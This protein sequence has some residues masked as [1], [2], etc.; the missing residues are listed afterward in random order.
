MNYIGYAPQSNEGVW[1]VN[2]LHRQ[3]ITGAWEP[4]GDPY[5]EHVALLI[6]PTKND[7]GFF[8]KSYKATYG[9]QAKSTSINNGAVVTN[10]KLV[11]NG[12]NQ[13][14]GLNDHEDWYFGT[15]DFY[16]RVKVSFDNLSGQKG[17]VTQWE[18]GVGGAWELITFNTGLQWG[19]TVISAGLTTGVE[20]DFEIT[21]ING[22]L[23]CRRDGVQTYAGAYT[24][25]LPD[26]IKGLHVGIYHG[27]AYPMA[28]KFSLLHIVKGRGYTSPPS[29]NSDTV[30]YIDFSTG[31][32]ADIAVNRGVTITKSGNVS[33]VGAGNGIYKNNAAINFT[34]SA[35]DYLVIPPR[36][37]FDL[38]PYTPY[39]LETLFIP[40][41]LPASAYV[42]YGRNGDGNSTWNSGTDYYCYVFSDGTLRAGIGTNGTEVNSGSNKVVLGIVN[43]VAVIHTGNNWVGVAVNGVVQ[44]TNIT[45][46]QI[47]AGPVYIGAPQNVNAFNGQILA[48]RFTIGSHRG[49][50]GNITTIPVPR[51]FPTQQ[52]RHNSDPYF[53]LTQILVQPKATDTAILDYAWKGDKGRRSFN[54]GGVL[55]TDWRRYGKTSGRYN[56]SSYTDFIWT[57]DFGTNDFL[58]R[59]SC[60]F[61]SLGEQ[62]PIG[63]IDASTGTNRAFTVGLNTSNIWTAGF[64]SGSSTYSLTGNTPA[65]VGVDYDVI[66]KRVNGT[67]SL[68]VNDVTV[69]T[70]SQPL[71]V[72]ASTA[73]LCIGRWGT[74]YYFNGWIDG[75]Q[76]VSGLAP[77]GSFANAPVNT[78]NTVLLLN[79]ENGIVDDPSSRIQLVTANGGV[80]VSSSGV[81]TGYGSIPFDGT[82]DYLTVPHPP[83]GIRDFIWEWDLVLTDTTTYRVI[84][85]GRPEAAVGPY[86]TL[87]MHNNNLYYL[88]N[89]STAAMGPNAIST[90]RNR[91][92]LARTDGT[93]RL[94]LN[95]TL[96]KSI[97]D[98]TSYVGTSLQIGRSSAA[99]DYLLGS[100]YSFRST[101]GTSRGVIGA[102][103]PV[104]STPFPVND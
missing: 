51:V 95:G 93:L 52:I 86:Q 37:Y 40:K 5:W 104:T 47:T 101:V 88:V 36:T 70:A 82:N 23:Y 102:T 80:S 13:Y 42:L 63:Q 45:P 62:Y 14:L 64:I 10:G 57:N 92:V 61:A 30:L 39:V 90:G 12:S 96:V 3:A 76:V 65:V 16:F 25:D 77:D 49:I 55:S 1:S 18:S 81:I 7:T 53:G 41:A 56:G 60:R 84:V 43:H 33:L 6:Q 24:T 20:Y 87:Y 58:V 11:L 71:A 94:Y 15:G 19:N 29:N 2:D 89:G 28:G 27:G 34:N 75:V 46:G 73:P 31:S 4:A 91:I 22:V 44:W 79:F 59:L 35:T 50:L 97:G 98:S 38:T 74:G 69:A 8:D 26:S 67:T 83:I 48:T 68:I 17:V 78:T 32:H 54:S 99:S 85:D 72:N 100:L 103:T 66:Y 21:R 9:A